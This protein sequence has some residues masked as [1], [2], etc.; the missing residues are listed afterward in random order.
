MLKEVMWVSK[1]IYSLKQRVTGADILLI[2]FAGQK[3]CLTLTFFIFLTD[4][5]PI[6][7]SQVVLEKLLVVVQCQCLE[8]LNL[9]P[10]SSP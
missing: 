8:S 1:V 2:F 5:E 7:L 3:L 6:A 10:V 4:V 9:Y